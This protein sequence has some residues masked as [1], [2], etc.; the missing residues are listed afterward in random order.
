MLID[1]Q[2]VNSINLI[3]KKDWCNCFEKDN[4]LQSY[5]LQKAIERSKIVNNFYY[6]TLSQNK[7]LIGIVCCFGFDYSITDIAP[8]SVQKIV[9][10]IRKMY[11]NFMRFRLLVVGSPIAT[12]TDLLG[13]SNYQ[14][15]KESDLI[16]KI[17]ENE[18]DK[19]AKEI[20]SDL[21]CIKELQSRVNKIFRNGL[22]SKFLECRSP[23]TTYVYTGYVD[24]MSYKEN[25]RRQYKYV[26]NK[27]EK[28]FKSLGL[29]WEV[30]TDFGDYAEQMHN[31]YLNVLSKSNVKFERLT[32]EFFHEINREL[33]GNTYALICFDKNKPIAFELF[34][35]GKNLHPIYLGMDYS[36]KDKAALYFNCLYRTIDEAKRKNYEFIELGQ[37]SYEVKLSIGA[38]SSSLF[39][40]VKHTNAFANYI[41]H[42]CSPLIFSVSKPLPLRNVFKF[43]KEY[44]DKLSLY[45]IVHNAD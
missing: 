42:I 24:G 33:K 37:T 23:D 5:E 30:V 38:V 9:K 15:Q 7:N 25:L 44:L 32:K 16:I 34:L 12:C 35:E 45:G 18:L 14:Q 6:L 13:I 31:L 11:K 4:I 3:S 21:I 17:I 8:L 2:W 36:Y 40:Y 43:Q 10:I 20:G 22:S 29:R 1:C 39:F 19:K 28:K 26:L 41:L 27:R